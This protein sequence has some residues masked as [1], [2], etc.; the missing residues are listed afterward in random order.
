MLYIEAMLRVSSRFNEFE[1]EEELLELEFEAPA[2]MK[3]L[4][5]NPS[6]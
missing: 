1:D 5:R 2:L 6:L 4:S 3:P